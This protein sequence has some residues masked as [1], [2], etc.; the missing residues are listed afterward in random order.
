M[1]EFEE[2]WKANWDYDTK[3]KSLGP[4]GA[5]TDTQVKGGEKK[6]ARK[7]WNAAIKQSSFTCRDNYVWITHLDKERRLVDLDKILND[8]EKLKTTND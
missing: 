1:T 4:R 5:I 7:A 3:D 8:L 2:W 6:A